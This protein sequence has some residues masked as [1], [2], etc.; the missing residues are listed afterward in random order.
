MS[1]KP[2][3]IVYRHKGERYVG[4][5]VKESRRTISVRNGRGLLLHVP[6]DA[7]EGPA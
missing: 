5:I 2:R 7:I 4:T 3:R 6:R 1:E